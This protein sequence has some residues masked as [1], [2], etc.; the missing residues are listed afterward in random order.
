MLLVSQ[1]GTIVMPFENMALFT[2]QKVA[3]SLY[4]IAAQPCGA[5]VYIMGQYIT[6]AQARREVEN[7]VSAMPRA[8]TAISLR[9]MR[10]WM[11]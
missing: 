7:A 9:T 2:V 1:D 5:S 8:M 3:D 6:V 4:A 11:R 10:L